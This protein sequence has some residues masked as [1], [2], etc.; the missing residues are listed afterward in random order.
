MTALGDDAKVPKK[1]LP[2][3]GKRVGKGLITDSCKAPLTPAR[4]HEHQ[5]RMNRVTTRH[6]RAY[7]SCPSFSQHGYTLARQVHSV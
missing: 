5:P 4:K 2:L 6:L 1:L 7:M 3:Y